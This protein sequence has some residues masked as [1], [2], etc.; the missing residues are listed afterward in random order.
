MKKVLAGMYQLRQQNKIVFSLHMKAIIKKILLRSGLLYRIQYSK[1]YQKYKIPDYYKEMNELSAFYHKQ[2]D[3]KHP[4]LVFDIGANVGDHSNIFSKIAKRLVCVEPDDLNN[5]ILRARFGRNKN[6]TII[7]KAVAEKEGTSVFYMEAAG[8]A[9]NTL[10]SKWVNVLEESEDSRFGEGHK[11][12]TSK[13]VA[14]TTLDKLINEYGKP[15][16]IKIDVEGFE[17]EVVSTL[18]EKISIISFECNLPEFLDETITIVEHLLS[19]NNNA[20][21]NLLREK[22]FELENNI[23]GQ[24]MIELINSGKYRFL[25]IFC[26]N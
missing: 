23:S 25:N 15:D 2:L 21:F 11:F 4:T 17:K 22:D 8:S 19:I 24:K 16:Y 14:I 1:W 7:K 26:F 20:Q 13:K 6:I 12:N 3:E 5:D 9:L 18:R 10:S